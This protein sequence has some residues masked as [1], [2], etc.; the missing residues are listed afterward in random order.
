MASPRK[1]RA[2]ILVVSQIIE[3]LSEH[4]LAKFA[5]TV[6]DVYSPRLVVVTTPNH[7]FNPWFD[8][9]SPPESR[10]GGGM[11]EPAPRSPPPPHGKNLSSSSEGSSDSDTA[12]A[13]SATISALHSHPHL[14][15]DPT[16]RTK[17]VFRDAD[18]K[19]EWTEEEFR[20]W[21]FDVADRYDYDLEITG[22]GSLSDY[23]GGREN[24]P[25]TPP[26]ADLH[27]ALNASSPSNSTSALPLVR[28]PD[29]FFATQ[30]AIFTRRYPNESERSPRSHHTSPLP[31]FSPLAPMSSPL[32]PASAEMAPAPTAPVSVLTGHGAPKRPPPGSRGT[33]YSSLPGE[34]RHRRQTSSASTGHSH[35]LSGTSGRATNPS[36]STTRGRQRSY[37]PALASSSLA[38]S[39]SSS[40][41][42][43][44]RTHELVWSHTYPRLALSSPASLAPV[45]TA[46]TAPSDE[47]S[48]SSLSSGATTHVSESALD[49]ADGGVGARVRA[50]LA[51]HFV[52]R[53]RQE[54]LSVHVLWLE[55]ADVRRA[56]A[57]Y[58]GELIDAL[59]E[60]TSDEWD[61][62]T[63]SEDSDDEE[64]ELAEGNAVSVRKEAAWPRPLRS[65]LASERLLVICKNPMSAD[66]KAA[67]YFAVRKQRRREIAARLKDP[68]KTPQAATDSDDDHGEYD[69]DADDESEDNC[70]SVHS[71]GDDFLSGDVTRQEDSGPPPT[72]A[73]LV[74]GHADD[75]W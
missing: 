70:P 17:R 12:A 6:F 2:L 3:H 26:S 48:P 37:S 28:Y 11:P 24:V 13:T 49:A 4:T 5:P 7:S 50:L 35:T 57:G 40:G 22:V 36:T 32:M 75:D 69:D 21:A 67:S 18:H 10:P 51:R 64:G 8:R 1:C 23:Y 68:L 66:A 63:V 61:L 46:P 72:S 43:I 16:G 42:A 15:P 30:T 74:A 73:G 29:R 19:F 9:R 60:D 71:S 59:I 54:R 25:N 53:A 31:F 14:F 27:P 39:I 55:A 52:H 41:Y 44:P 45:R 20:R 38:S 58:I 33:S 34:L 65:A 62:E 56:C 47:F